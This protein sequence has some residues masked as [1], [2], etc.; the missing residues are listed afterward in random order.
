MVLKD[1]MPSSFAIIQHSIQRMVCNSLLAYY[2]GEKSRHH[3]AKGIGQYNWLCL[4]T[5]CASLLRR[6][7]RLPEMDTGTC[8][9]SKACAFTSAPGWCYP[10]VEALDVLL[11]DARHFFLYYL[12]QSPKAYK[13]VYKCCCKAREPYY[14]YKS[15]RS[16]LL[17]HHIQV[18]TTKAPLPCCSGQ[19]GLEWGSTETVCSSRRKGVRRDFVIEGETDKPALLVSIRKWRP[20]HT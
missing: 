14:P 17:M 6:Y 9:T 5:I 3:F 12:A 15:M 4:L 7:S 8:R 2:F 10:Q 1:A 13:I 16:I 11:Q 18:V 20:V 19:W